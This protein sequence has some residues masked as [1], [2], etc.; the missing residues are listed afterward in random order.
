MERLLS[1]IF[2]LNSWLIYIV[3]SL[4]KANK[5]CSPLLKQVILSLEMWES[6]KGALKRWNLTLW[7]FIFHINLH[8]YSSLWGREQNV[9]KSV[10]LET[11]SIERVHLEIWRQENE[12]RFFCGTEKRRPRGRETERNKRTWIPPTTLIFVPSTCLNTLVSFP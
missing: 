4:F 5:N 2:P 7:F 6:S 11:V 3:I 1:R 12:C 8:P 10:N 9:V